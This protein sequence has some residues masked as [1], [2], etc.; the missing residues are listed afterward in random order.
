[1][2]AWAYFTMPTQEELRQRQAEQARQDSIAAAQAR[3]QPQQDTTAR[4]QPPA[5]QQEQT[6]RSADEEEEIPE[7]GMFERAS[8]TDTSRITIQTPLYES[9][10]TNVGAG[11]ST[12]TLNNYETWD[13]QPVQMIGDTTR[14][15]YS[16]GFLTNE[17]YN[18]ESNY[19]VFKQVTPGNSIRVEPGETKE[20]EY[21]L[22]LENGRSIIY[23][24]TFSG[25]SY[26]IDLSISFEGLERVI[27][28]N[29]VDFGWEPRLRF[30]EKNRTTEGQVT[31][32]YVFAG[33]EM[34]QFLLSEAGKDEQSINGNIEWV[35]TRTKFFAQVI[36]SVTPTDG[37]LLV[38]EV[39][40]SKDNPS[41]IHHYQS[42]IRADIPQDRVTEFKMYVG[43][44]S[45]NEVK[46]FDPNVYELV[47]VGWSWIRW[48]SDPLVR[49]I[50]IP[51]FSFTNNFM[52]YGLAIILFAIL[53][54]LIL[55]PLTKKSYKSMAAMKEL[56]PQMKEIQEKYK[57]DPQ[58][59]QEATLKLYKKAKVNPLGGCLPNLLQFPILI[60][61]WRFFQN[62]ILIRQQSFLWAGDLSA[63]DY[64]LSLPL[65]IPFLGDQLAG[66][67][68]L[69]TGAMVVQT[70]VTGGM[71]GG[72]ASAGQMKAFQYILPVMLLFI[73][74]NFAAGLSLYY[75][76]YNVVSIGQ[77]LLINKQLESQ[78]EGEEQ[79]KAK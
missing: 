14:S 74:N 66:F 32:A 34:E 52:N 10:F 68:L 55:Y 67:V 17:N 2:V 43:P 16:M 58:K 64:I 35:A 49:Y 12:F 44:L 4:Q 38:G 70:Q 28:G 21:R 46:K 61:L 56:Q 76:I 22:D 27:I 73:F 6:L 33:G 42:Y 3:Q 5:Q 36:K 29:T 62:S 79:E 9:V 30:T 45:Y 23:T 60:T 59:Q 77:Q 40:G 75:L 1:M 11:P 63:P 25:D 18:V 53:V 72:G 13:H 41:T 54:K 51:F 48:F 50:V 31:S 8:I 37:A 71:S 20:L 7:M 24:Y 47:D 78:K 57:D 19:L 69:M 26:E 39:T 65:S 15:A